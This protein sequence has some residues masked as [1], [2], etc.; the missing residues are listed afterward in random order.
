MKGMAGSPFRPAEIEAFRFLSDNARRFA[1]F[2]TDFI[3]APADREKK[4]I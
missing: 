4:E 3:A 1:G 2:P